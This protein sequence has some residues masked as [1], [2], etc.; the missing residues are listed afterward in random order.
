MAKHLLAICAAA[1]MLGAPTLAL[2][3]TNPASAPSRN[4]PPVCPGPVSPWLTALL[5]R[6]PAGG[7]ALRA[8]IAR[9][10]ET[11]PHLAREV[12]AAA[13]GAN[14]D[15]KEAIAAGMADAANFFAKLGSEA[16]RLAE[17]EIRTAMLT[18]DPLTRY[19][20]QVASFSTFNEAIPGFGNAGVATNRCV[21][22]SKSRPDDR[23]CD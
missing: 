10:L 22:I 15:Q 3:Q 19:W 12:V 8:E 1:V 4:P 7:P 11:N 23:D 16:A 17:N 13:C 2:A 18:A 6:F 20:F 14:P 21:K 5:A 9:L